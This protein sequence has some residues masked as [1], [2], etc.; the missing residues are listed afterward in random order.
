MGRHC[1]VG[2][3]AIPLSAIGNPTGPIRSCALLAMPRDTP[4]VSSGVVQRADPSCR[5]RGL[6]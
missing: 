6:D 4:F 1:A 3:L 2:F 5:A